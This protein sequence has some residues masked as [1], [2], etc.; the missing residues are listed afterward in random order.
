MVSR[1]QLE[2]FTESIHCEPRLNRGERKPEMAGLTGFHIEPDG[3][4][5]LEFDLVEARVQLA[6]EAQVK[7]EESVPKALVVLCRATSV[8]LP[9]SPQAR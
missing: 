3:S 9:P 6:A 2:Q 4:M 1:A 7:E 5:L 8:A